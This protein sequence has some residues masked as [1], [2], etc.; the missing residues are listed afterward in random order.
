[1]TLQLDDLIG[2]TV[3]VYWNI[4]RKVWSVRKRNRVVAHLAALTIFSPTFHV[5]EAG[6]QRVL[7]ERRK[8][9]H[10]FIRGELYAPGLLAET[11]FQVSYNPYKGPTFYRVGSGET[12]LRGR[13]AKLDPGPLVTMSV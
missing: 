10:A 9:V 3:S 6:R 4:R 1:M 13:W 7:R 5:S 12:V 8:N 2:Q 11:G